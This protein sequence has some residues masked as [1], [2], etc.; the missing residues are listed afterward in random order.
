[1]CE[2]EAASS[3]G[4]DGGNIADSFM[5]VGVGEEYTCDY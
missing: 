1:M 3:D 5:A 2:L 4:G